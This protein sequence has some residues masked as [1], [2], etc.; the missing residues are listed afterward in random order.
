MLSYFIIFILN[1][2]FLLFMLSL[3][4]LV[5]FINKFLLIIINNIILIFYILKLI[6]FLVSYFIIMLLIFCKIFTMSPTIPLIINPK[7]SIKNR[8]VVWGSFFLTSLNTLFIYIKKSINDIDEFYKTL[9]LTITLGLIC[10]LIINSTLFL[11]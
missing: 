2:I 6:V 4:D 3:L 11:I 7:L 10:L 9:I 5:N 1:L 8:Y